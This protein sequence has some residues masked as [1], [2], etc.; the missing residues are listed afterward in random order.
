MLDRFPQRDLVL[1][2]LMCPINIIPFLSLVYISATTPR[3][4]TP[5]LY[6]T[7]HHAFTTTAQLSRL[8]ISRL[9][10]QGLPRPILTTTGY[11]ACCVF[12]PVI[13][14]ELSRSTNTRTSGY[15][16]R[17]SSSYFIVYLSPAF[18]PPLPS[19]LVPPPGATLYNLLH[20]EVVSNIMSFLS[21]VCQKYLLDSEQEHNLPRKL[22]QSTLQKSSVMLEGM[23]SSRMSK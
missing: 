13:T 22:L 1:W 21:L 9:P 23:I 18:T 6:R 16:A 2:A 8:C 12:I 5:H 14:P 17:H 3:A 7:G 4:T 10:R 19:P 20:T 11:H 15:H